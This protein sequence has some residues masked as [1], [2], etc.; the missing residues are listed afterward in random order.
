MLSAGLRHL[1][2]RRCVPQQ[3][4]MSTAWPWASPPITRQTFGLG[5]DAVGSK[6]DFAFHPRNTSGIGSR[7]RERAANFDRW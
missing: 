4:R 6:S 3:N 1:N 2:E 7:A 5:G